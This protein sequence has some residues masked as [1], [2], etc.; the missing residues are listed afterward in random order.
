M[1]PSPPLLLALLALITLPTAASAQSGNP[2]L[3]AGMRLYGD[4]EYE[5]ALQQ[6]TKATSLPGNT[7][8]VEVE[9]AVH[10]GL[11]RF[12]LGD[13]PG[14]ELDFKTALAFDP[15][16]KLPEGVAPKIKAVFEQARAQILAASPPK[17]TVAATVTAPTSVPPLPPPPPAAT[18][19]TRPTPVSVAPPVAPREI[20][21]TAPPATDTS[22]KAPAEPLALPRQAD[23]TVRTPDDAAAAAV[24]APA[25]SPTIE[26]RRGGSRILAGVLLGAGAALAGGGAYFGYQSSG[27]VD[28]A[29]AAH[30]QSD[31][32]G[33]LDRAHSQALT[34]NV[35][36]GAAAA[37]A[38]GGFVSLFAD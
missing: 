6:L 28:E 31:G 5:A 1:R 9:I 8:A 12:E 30:F 11:I 22:I 19:T 7:P 18:T 24:A 17:P 29:R 15:D 13:Q 37:A 21:P 27:S 10:R 23:L 35:L 3:D 33:S 2:Y 32:A 14:A 26:P 25:P 20:A 36:Y 16:A 38:I 4:F 34:A